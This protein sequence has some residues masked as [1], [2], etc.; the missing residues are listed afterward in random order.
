M[1][2]GQFCIRDTVI[3]KKGDTIVEA[4]KVMRKHHVGSVVVVEESEHGCKPVGILTDRDLVVEIL[5]EE[6]APEAV[7]V[8]DVMSFELVTAREQDGLWETLQR[9]RASGVRRIPVVDDR[10]VLVG[11]VSADDYLEILSAELGELA[12][13]LGREQGRE[14]RTRGA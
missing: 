13:L 8:G 12:K 1:S 2:I 10:G 4:A 3:V 5:A 14:E 6:V 9:M 11:I 7:T